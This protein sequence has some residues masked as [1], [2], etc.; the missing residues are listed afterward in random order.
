[1]N[2]PHLEET[3]ARFDGEA[4]AAHECDE[5]RAFVADAARL[6][7]SLRSMTFDTSPRRRFAAVLVP[8]TLVLGLV[9]FLVLR[10][11]ARQE[12]AFAGL[13]GGGR[14]AITVKP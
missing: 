11:E 7:S 12:G 1:M 4:I 3:S 8:A 2:C 6:R 9:L 14:A 10:R 5:C 13:D